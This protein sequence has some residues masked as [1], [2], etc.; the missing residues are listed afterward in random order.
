MNKILTLDLGDQ[1]VGTAIT[2]REQLF[3]RPYKT[4]EL[5]KLEEFLKE[6]IKLEEI[7]QVIIGYPKTMGGKISDQ[8]Q[9]VINKKEELAK[10]FPDIE[11]ILWDERLSSK[12]AQTVGKIKSK[13][14]KIKSHSIAA[15]FILDTYLEYLKFQKNNSF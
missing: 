12:R 9:K 5:N 4:V 13:E 2:D 14:D 7:K 10:N 8:T 1:W 6:T 3:A 15:A 11:F